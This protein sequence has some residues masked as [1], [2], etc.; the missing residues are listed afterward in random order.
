MIQ[1]LLLLIL[2]VT[3]FFC[4]LSQARSQQKNEIEKIKSAF[5]EAM[6]KGKREK[7]LELEETI[8]K[9]MKERK[10]LTDKEVAI[11]FTLAGSTKRE[12]F[13]VKE[14]LPF[15][16]KALELNEKAF[17]K[18]SIQAL[19]TKKY[20]SWCYGDLG[21]IEK[22]RKYNYELLDFYKTDEKKYPIE[23]ADLYNTIGMGY[24]LEANDIGDRITEQRLLNIGKEILEK[25]QPLHDSIKHAKYFNLMN[26]YNS[27]S[28]SYFASNKYDQALRFARKSLELRNIYTPQNVERAIN[29]MLIGRCLHLMEEDYDSAFYYLNKSINLLEQKDRAGQSMIGTS[30]WTTYKSYKAKISVAAGRF[31][32]A[33]T[34][35]QF[36]I[37]FIQKNNFNGTSHES[38]LQNYEV[39]SRSLLEKGEYKKALEI[40]KEALANIKIDNKTKSVKSTNFKAQYATALSSNKEWDNASKEFES[41]LIETGVSM[42]QLLNLSYNIPVTVPQDFLFVF[43]QAA[44]HL[45]EKGFATGNQHDVTSGIL[46]LKKVCNSLEKRKAWYFEAGIDEGIGAQD[47]NVYNDLLNS[48]YLAKNIIPEH[49]RLAWAFAAIEE[50]KASLL[51]NKLT[52]DRQMLAVLPDSI[53]R[54]RLDLKMKMYEALYKIRQHNDEASHDNLM[55]SK[56]AYMEYFHKI[57]NKYFRD[58]AKADNTIAVNNLILTNYRGSIINYFLGNKYLFAFIHETGKQKFIRKDIPAS[59]ETDLFIVK[60]KCLTKSIWDDP[61]TVKEAGS[62]GKKWYQWLLGDVKSDGELVIIPHKQL[63]LI[64]FEMLD[65]NSGSGKASYLIENRPVRYELSASLMQ[66][67][68]EKQSMNNITQFGGFASSNFDINKKYTTSND[69]LPERVR[70]SIDQTL[71]G[72]NKEVNGITRMLRG[73]AYL[74]VRPDDFLRHAE[75][76]RIVHIATHALADQ[77]PSHECNLIFETD[78]TGNN[79]V[80]DVQIASLKLQAEMAVLS[81]CNTGVGK[82]HNS[83]GMLNLGRSFFIA[84]CPSVVMSL[85][86]VNDAS[87]AI[88]MTDFYRFLQEGKTKSEALRHAKLNYLENE[89][90]PAKKHPYYWAGFIVVGSNDP[91]KLSRSNQIFT[92]VLISMAVISIAGVVYYFR[93]RSRSSAA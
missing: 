16:I 62:I 32:E 31:N 34:E 28:I 63:S 42:K 81:A 64:S 56:E 3:C 72:T 79:I 22:E 7:L 30:P 14:A 69:V 49:D 13:K 46:I 24:G 74:H 53:N 11:L 90:N 89:T 2:S 59:F 43:K 35:T 10:D 87:T 36:L 37:K 21:Y 41:T 45:I 83:E 15:M 80:R 85:W 77:G 44:N 50:P 33:I 78:S 29:M 75:K 39:L 12:N 76:Y 6:I 1:N 23:I 70:G 55:K 60:Q 38:L 68:G 40:C 73:D 65:V 54:K 27:L 57:K 91:L 92:W 18:N 61:K 58:E 9:R 82:M 66:L 19:E 84:G 8:M 52:D 71:V 4:N 51:K 67:R 48:L 20:L 88:I 86:T 25:F 93:K 17:G 5:D 26:I 47:L